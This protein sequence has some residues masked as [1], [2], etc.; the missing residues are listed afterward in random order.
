MNRNLSERFDRRQ[1]AVFVRLTVLLADGVDALQRRILFLRLTRLLD[2]H[3]S[4]ALAL[5]HS[6]ALFVHL[7]DEGIDEMASC[8][9]VLL[10]A[11]CL[12]EGGLALAVGLLKVADAGSQ[13]ILH[14]SLGL[15][16]RLRCSDFLVSR[17]SHA[18]DGKLESGVLFAAWLVDHVAAVA[19]AVHWLLRRRAKAEEGLLGSPICVKLA[20]CKHWQSF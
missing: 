20:E 7:L 8:I 19:D 17:A 14:A 5:E 9:L 11:Q 10:I 13:V 16:E 18:L 1:R 4:V 15:V 3:L 2:L 12:K 6:Q